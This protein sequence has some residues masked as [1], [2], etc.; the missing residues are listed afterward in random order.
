MIRH[1]KSWL[2]PRNSILKKVKYFQKMTLMLIQRMEERK[3]YKMRQNHNCH[4]LSSKKE[5]KNSSITT[6]TSLTVGSA[7]SGWEQQQEVLME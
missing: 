6:M 7:T 1:Y 4:T 3:C 2:Q 5:K